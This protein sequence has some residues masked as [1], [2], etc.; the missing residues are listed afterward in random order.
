MT[1]NSFAMVSDAILKQKIIN[2][3]YRSY[4]NQQ[5]ERELSPQTLIYYKENWYLDAWCHLRHDLR[6]FSLA[7]IEKISLTK[8]KA[9]S[10]PPPTTQ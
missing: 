10:V 3:G 1:G 5:S 4:S 8:Q 9:K 7:R 2:V 6:T